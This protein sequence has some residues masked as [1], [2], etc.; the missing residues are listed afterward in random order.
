MKT[1]AL[2]L[3]LTSGC[4]LDMNGLEPT[5]SSSD[6]GAA[7]NPEASIPLDAGDLKLDAGS[8]YAIDQNSLQLACQS[9]C[10]D[11]CCDRTG[12]CHVSTTDRC[13]RQGYACVDCGGHFCNADG[14]CSLENTD[15]GADR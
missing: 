14:F 13:G 5:S 10:P 8:L 3:L 1:L 6:S 7:S 12:I 9:L 15:P 4:A 11:G 2:L